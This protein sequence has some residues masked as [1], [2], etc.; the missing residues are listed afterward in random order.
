MYHVFFY[1]IYILCHLCNIYN[2]TDPMTRTYYLFIGD[3]WTELVE[4]KITPCWVHQHVDSKRWPILGLT[5]FLKQF[6]CWMIWIINHSQLGF[7]EKPLAQ[8]YLKQWSK[9]IYLQRRLRWWKCRDMMQDSFRV[10]N[11]KYHFL[12]QLFCMETALI[13]VLIYMYI[14][15]C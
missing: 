9:Q 15:F 11:C 2:T 6:W 12:L 5:Y 8:R 10:F 14:H 13:Y 1:N 3:V 7:D 4:M